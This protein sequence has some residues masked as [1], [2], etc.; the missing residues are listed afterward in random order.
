MS[1]KYTTQ[2]GDISLAV[3][4][5]GTL[6]T[7]SQT[8][9]LAHACTLPNSAEFSAKSLYLAG[10]TLT[11]GAG[12][13]HAPK[14]YLYG[15]SGLGSG[16]LSG[17]ENLATLACTGMEVDG[18]G[19]TTVGQGWWC[20]G[21]VT[22]TGNV[23]CNAT[24]GAAHGFQLSS[25][26]TFGCVILTGTGAASNFHGILNAGT[27][28]ATCIG[29]GGI[30]TRDGGGGINNI[31][32]INGD[33][34]GTGGAASYISRDPPC[35]GGPGIACNAGAIVGSCTGTGGVGEYGRGGVGIWLYN[36][37][38]ITGDCN[39]TGGDGDIGGNG[40]WAQ[41]TSTVVGDCVGVGGQPTVWDP[42]AGIAMDVMTAII[43]STVLPANILLGV[44]I[45]GVAGTL[46][47]TAD[48]GAVLRLV[49]D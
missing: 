10:Y 37:G 9:E 12:T 33:C 6:P 24:G 19:A 27:I 3:T 7:A 39:G 35:D 17:L 36:A 25:G 1:D 21:T 15:D 2:A 43:E 4:W 41:D 13:T 29:T 23:T 42:G 11:C 14:I 48:N 18:H 31:G 44:T 26:K 45:L 46:D 22:F 47:I 16:T 49:P 32:T 20:K 5:G 28:N 38:A 8:A 34:T 40:I 30:G